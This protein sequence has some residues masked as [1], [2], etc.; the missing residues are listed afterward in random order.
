MKKYKIL[1]TFATV[2]SVTAIA[3]YG[4]SNSSNSK[5]ELNNSEVVEESSEDTTDKSSTESNSNS[6]SENITNNTDTNTNTTNSET[7]ST[8]ENFNDGISTNHP[9]ETNSNANIPTTYTKED[10]SKDGLVTGDSGIKYG[11]AGDSSSLTSKVIN[12]ERC[13]FVMDDDCNYR[14]IG[15]NTLNIYD[16]NNKVIDKAKLR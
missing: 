9:K 1:L 4:C 3:V 6:L 7:N 5:K 16:E 11:W 13:L 2:V 8:T 12:D 15:L 10:I 14:Y